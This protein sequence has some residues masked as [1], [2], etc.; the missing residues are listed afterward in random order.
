MS[1]RREYYLPLR[2]GSQGCTERQTY[3]YDRKSD[4]ADSSRHY[5]EHPWLCIQHSNPD[6][7]LT[8]DN[9]ANSVVFV[10]T[11]RFTTIRAEQHSLGLFWVRE[12]TE[13]SVRASVSGFDFSSA[14]SAHAKNFPVGTR[15][16]VTAYTETPE[17]AE[18]A[19]QA[20]GVA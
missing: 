4:Q 20:D 17:Q 14:H 8:V 16:V 3:H 5:R 12:G 7:F 10:A 15:L 9:P 6:K 19:R 11:E 18:I 1:P 2:C 13:A